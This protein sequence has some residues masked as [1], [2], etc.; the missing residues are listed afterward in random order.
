MHSLTHQ[1]KTKTTCLII[2]TKVLIIK[3]C[4]STFLGE[5]LM[6]KFR[7]LLL[8]FILLLTLTEGM[9]LV[10]L[11]MVGNTRA[12]RMDPVLKIFN[13]TIGKENGFQNQLIKDLH[14]LLIYHNFFIGLVI[15]LILHQMILR[16]YGEMVW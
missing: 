2:Q 12:K 15:V 5:A 11:K 1:C 6:F 13:E 7:H 9:A 4:L 10:E 3:L 8:P 16:D 14:Q